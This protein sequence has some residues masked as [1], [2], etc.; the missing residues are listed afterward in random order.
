MNPVIDRLNPAD[1]GERLRQARSQAN[2]TQEQAAT[3]LGVARTTLV[4]IE[5][6]QRRVRPEDLEA[7][8]RMYGAS[9]HRFLRP[10]AV[11]V[12]LT[13]RFR[14]LSE[15]NDPDTEAAARL[16]N[17]LVSAEIELE[18][19]VGR[20]L[21]RDYPAERPI[22][23]G[24]LTDQAED[25]A[26]EMRQRLGL[27]VAP[28]PDLV[29]ILQLDLG[30]R[31]FIRPLKASI[32]GLFVYDD[33]A[34]ACILLNQNHR[35]TRRALTAAH[36]FAHL[37]TARREPDVLECEEGP[38]SRTERF[39]SAFAVAFM[40]PASVVRT[41][42]RE[43]QQETG[44]FSPRHL[45]LMA[46]SLHAS[47]EAMCRRLEDLKLLPGGTW[48]SLRDRGFS[49]Q[50]AQEVLGDRTTSDDVSVPPRLWMLAAEAYQ[51]EL[52]S[53]GQLA[54]MLRMDRLEIR[55]V[56]D[57]FGDDE[58]WGTLALDA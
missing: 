3:D 45:I 53:E 33:D 50:L 42:F 40:M 54:Q 47:T 38:K 18:R 43:H 23:A 44:R 22:L 37:I 57:L 55:R 29:S 4:A 27:G 36:E 46:H 14:K 11:Q 56:L 10:S 9:V 49:G 39:A 58:S 19:L 26:G 34:G 48:D 12:D 20:P 17:E 51:R 41:R 24:S 21:K 52:V 32:S 28:I 1:L 2:L 13:P 25:M 16:L 7:F 5:K 35:R 8:A 15:S 6:G 31:I 30:V